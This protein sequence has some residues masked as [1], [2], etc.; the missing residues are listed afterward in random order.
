VSVL[1]A[2]LVPVDRH[3]ETLKGLLDGVIRSAPLRRSVDHDQSCQA[4]APGRHRPQLCEDECVGRLLVNESGAEN[5]RTVSA[6]IDG[7]GDLVFSGVDWG[8]GVEEFF[9]RDEIE[10]W[11]TV[12]RGDLGAFAKVAS[13]DPDRLLE[14]LH[15][16]WS[17]ARFNELA[18]LMRTDP[19]EL[20][21]K[22]EQSLY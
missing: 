20:G 14:S 1:V 13:V 7:A 6:K 12:R 18:D 22:V 8:P 16:K 9:G 21:F 17:G 3:L 11:Y 4:P 19:D 10:F 2:V 5:P 15:E